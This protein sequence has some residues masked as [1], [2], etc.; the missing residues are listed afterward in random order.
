MQVEN[1]PELTRWNI[2]QI[3]DAVP[4]CPSL[5]MGASSATATHMIKEN[6]RQQLVG[7]HIRQS[8]GALQALKDFIIMSEVRAKIRDDVFAGLRAAESLTVFLSQLS[9]DAFKALGDDKEAANIINVLKG[10]FQTVIDHSRPYTTVHF[11][12]DYSPRPGYSFTYREAYDTRA[13]F[14]HTSLQHFL[15]PNGFVVGVMEEYKEDHVSP[16]IRGLRNTINKN[17][18]API[19]KPG[20]WTHLYNAIY[21][22][23]G[24]EAC[25][26]TARL[27]FDK[28]TMYAYGITMNQLSKILC[29]SF[30]E[31]CPVIIA[32]SFSDA[33][34]DIYPSGIITAPDEMEQTEGIYLEVYKENILLYSSL[35]SNLNQIRVGGIPYQVSSKN[36]CPKVIDLKVHT[37]K[38]DS[39]YTTKK[40]VGK[41]SIPYKMWT[42]L[43]GIKGKHLTD[44]NH[45]HFDERGSLVYSEKVV[46]SK[47]PSAQQLEKTFQDLGKLP[48]VNTHYIEELGRDK[49]AKELGL[50][51]LTWRDLEF[52]C[53]TDQDKKIFYSR[54]KLADTPLATEQELNKF[55]IETFLAGESLDNLWVLELKVA[56]MVVEG[57]EY[58]NMAKFLTYCGLKIHSVEKHQFLNKDGYIYILSDINPDIIIK[59]HFEEKNYTYQNLF[60]NKSLS[61][62][63]RKLALEKSGG[64]K[65]EKVIVNML[66]VPNVL[67]LERIHTY[68]YIVL[69]TERKNKTSAYM[70]HI[71]NHAYDQIVRFPWVDRRKTISNDWYN[72][73]LVLGVDIAH[74]NYMIE[75]HREISACG[76][77]IDPRHLISFTALVF[78]KGF[79]AGSGLKGVIT[80]GIDFLTEVFTE[81]ADSQLLKGYTRKPSTN[82]ALYLFTGGIATRGIQRLKEAE[83]A[84]KERLRENEIIRSQARFGKSARYPEASKVITKTENNTEVAARILAIR[85]RILSGDPFAGIETIIV[86]DNR[87]LQNLA[88]PKDYLI[89]DSLQASDKELTRTIAREMIPIRTKL[90]NTKRNVAEQTARIIIKA[91]APVVDVEEMYIYI[92]GL[93]NQLF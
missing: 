40:V 34:I 29:Q 65:N 14:L 33:V 4:P 86:L 35:K 79:P 59:N 6:I 26:Y 30:K 1:I 15:L 36:T 69:H 62:E 47:H 27:L 19:L 70:E 74:N 91:S 11:D 73:N 75:P 78:E 63:A 82:L 18:G 38:Y 23:S 50:D 3:C 87:I 52:N 24:T 56:T 8:E 88:Y 28:Q 16:V 84:S 76:A 20:P 49:W 57:I 45:Y 10:I 39:L 17:G 25:I 9:L 13:Y 7:K 51:Y 21:G 48:I 67:E 68:C 2:N 53:Y 80:H 41:E 12:L 66:S 37:I 60:I 89:S 31:T 5:D 92:L 83:V 85:S 72:V 54:E 77:G 71:M 55:F 93:G 64:S 58:S 81:K 32:S 90:Y 61:D 44:P 43:N 42:A 46:D 22:T